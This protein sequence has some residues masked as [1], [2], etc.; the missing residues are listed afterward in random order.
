MINRFM[1]EVVS[2]GAVGLLP[3]NLSEEWLEHLA[4]GAKKFLLTA[5]N[6]GHEDPGEDAEPTDPFED[7]ESTM[8][9]TAV[10]EILQFQKG[11][12]D[13]TE[14]PEIPKEELF[15]CLS[16]YALW[17]VITYL[18]KVLE[19][20]L[21][22]PGVENVFEREPVYEMEQRFP[23]LTAALNGFISTDLQ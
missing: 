1:D 6:K 14:I 22:F 21:E 12:A 11:Y 18:G 23:Q 2:K 4:V 19:L 20:S 5:M 9:L 3:Q 17:V 15:E 8:L 10:M 16:C 7:A 13:D